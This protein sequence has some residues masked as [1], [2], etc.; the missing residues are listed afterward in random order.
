MQDRNGPLD[1][2]GIFRDGRLIA[3]APDDTEEAYKLRDRLAK[4]GHPGCEVLGRCNAHPDTAAVD[5]LVCWPLGE[6]D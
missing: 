3:E 6:D 5:C 4:E 1:A 2:L